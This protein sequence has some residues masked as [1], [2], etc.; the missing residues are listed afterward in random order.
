MSF[1]LLTAES[2]SGELSLLSLPKSSDITW[3]IESLAD[4]IGTLDV[5]QMTAVVPIPA[6]V[7]LFCSALACLG[8]RRRNQH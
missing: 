3:D 7:W 1:D 8:W 6:A 4:E 5:V 2:I